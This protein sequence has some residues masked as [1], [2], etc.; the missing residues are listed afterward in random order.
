MAKLSDRIRSMISRQVKSRGIVIWYD[1]EKVYAGVVQ[2]LDFPGTTVLQYADSLFRLRHE[3]EPHLE[4]V[5]AEAKPKDGCG[6]AP[7]VVI[8]IPMERGETSFALIEAETAGVVVEPGAESPERNSRLRV[9]TE[10]FFLEVAPEKATHLARQVEEG[11]LTLEDLDRISE[12]VSSIT[13][14]ALKLVFGA[15]S[16]IESIIEFASGSGK[17]AKISQKKALGELR[18]LAQ[19]ELGLDFGDTSSPKDARRSLRR[20]ILLA[21]FTAAIPEAGR[22]PALGPVN[23]PEKPV[24]LDALKH[25]C[26]TWRNRVDFRDG[27]I[28]AARDLEEAAGISQM[29]LNP[30]DVKAVETFPCIEFLLIRSAQIA[31]LEGRMEEALRLAESRKKSFWS[32]EQPE[33]LLRWSAMELA[34]NFMKEAAKLSDRIKSLDFSVSEMVRA[35]ALFSEPWMMADR[36]HRHFESR[37]LNLDPD[38]TEEDDFEKLIAKIRRKYADLADELNRAF[39]GRYKKA[40]FEIEGILPQARIAIKPSSNRVPRVPWGIMATCNF[41]VINWNL[42]KEIR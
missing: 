41:S 7:N 17:D 31:L 8:Y 11:L 23:L 35:Y 15:A 29:A 13:S 3:L 37:L 5:T 6:V 38:E 40:G 27:Y 21:E 25:L 16:P 18:S 24:Q 42:S 39:V 22:P 36:L 20:M 33:L 19:S 9:Q 4:F 12:E 14:G 30:D 32:R 10:S 26:E 34:G 2:D 28:Q 1:P